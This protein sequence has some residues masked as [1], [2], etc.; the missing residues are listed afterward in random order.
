MNTP[1]VLVTGATDGIGTE[2]ALELGRR[3]ARVIVHGRDA[4][5][6]ERVRALL[7]H[8]TK[9]T[10]P[11][12]VVFDLASFGA[13]RAG[14]QALANRDEPLDVVVHNAGVFATTRTLSADGHEL[15]LHVNH[16]APVLLTH[17]LMPSLLRAPQGRV[18]LVS[19]MAHGRGRIDFDD[20]DLARGYD[21]YGAYAASKL[22][23]ILFAKELSVRLQGT[24]VT[25]NALHPGVVTTKLLREGFGSSGPDSH[26]EGA[27][28]SV[29]LAL[30]PDV[31]TTSGRYFVRKA[32]ATPSRAAQNLDDARRLYEL[33]CRLVDVAPLPG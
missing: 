29:Y 30:S 22:M 28:T 12:G 10:P 9:T 16:L 6:V 25:A 13:T 14:A 15:S 3:G 27:A 23:N 18:V 5:K 1:L 20:L 17:V 24:P 8:E 33:S 7:S 11:A 26:A 4:Q 2:T 21:G 31:T 19:S 32:E